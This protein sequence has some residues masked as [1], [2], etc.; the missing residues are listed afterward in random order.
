[1]SKEHPKA[2]PPD[3]TDAAESVA[4]KLSYISGL[5]ASVKGEAMNWLRDPNLSTALRLR[6]E[7][8][9]A[10]VEATTVEARRRVRLNEGDA[11]QG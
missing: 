6:L 9:H 4:K 1:V 7:N 5:L 3:H 2:R 8:A 11:R 10:A